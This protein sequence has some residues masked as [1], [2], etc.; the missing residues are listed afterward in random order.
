[1]NEIFWL[2]TLASYERYEAALRRPEF[3]GF[4]A[5]DLN[6]DTEYRDMMVSLHG[7]VAII[8]I[9]GSL[10]AGQTGSWGAYFGVI[11]Y[12]DI[13]AAVM[14][15]ASRPEVKSLVYNIDSGGGDV[16]G[17][18]GTAEFIS[19]MST[20]K[21]SVTFTDGYLASAAAWIG[22][23]TNYVVA[24]DTSLVGSVGI[25][26]VHADRSKFFEE[27]GIKYTVTRAGEEKALA[28]PY[29]PL[30]DKAKANL[31]S[32]V[33]ALYD[34]FINRMALQRGVTKD[35]ADSKFG[36]GREFIGKQAMSAGLVDKIGT[37]E[38]AIV[39]ARKLAANISKVKGGAVRASIDSS[40]NSPTTEKSMPTPLTAEQLEALAQT[41]ASASVAE[42]E[43]PPTQ[44]AKEPETTA[45]L[46]VASEPSVLDKLLSATADLATE[47]AASAQLRDQLSASLESSKNLL[48][49]ARQQVKVLGLHFGVT[50]AAVDTMDAAAVC[51][52]YDRLSAMF[53]AKFP[54]GRV[55]APSA[56][57][58]PA[59][60]KT[61]PVDPL[62]VA[63]VQAAKN[64]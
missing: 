63:T 8:N 54:G 59:K 19:K 58:S 42:P 33:D 44:P 21:P 50:S 39:K 61:T 37:L 60:P 2:G 31:Q 24:S 12:E 5:S 40:D 53:V 35:V 25:L 48:T 28:N 20:V 36:Q 22:T 41:G 13:K 49:I 45:T 16:A 1:M 14:W 6:T 46:E 29:E 27:N 34:V 17:V 38:D 55:A 7:D 4:K 64:R 52:E 57:A 11:G 10:V 32:R 62:Y 51:A 30:T 56:S 18:N 15:A 3:I 26:T 23:A 9:T 47:K 43:T